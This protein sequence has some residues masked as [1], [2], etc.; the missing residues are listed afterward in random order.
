MAPKRAPVTATITMHRLYKD[1]P[2]DRNGDVPIAIRQM[3]MHCDAVMYR[4]SKTDAVPSYCLT[5]ACEWLINCEDRDIAFDDV[6]L[7]VR[8]IN[9]KDVSEIHSVTFELYSRALTA[10]ELRE[11]VR[12]LHDEY[13][14]FTSQQL[15]S[16]PCI[17]EQRDKAG[18]FRGSPFDDAENKK[19]HD[20]ANAPKH[21]AF[22]KYPFQSNKTF[23]SLC[24]PDAK[25]VCDRVR[26]FMDNKAWYDAKGIPYRL[27]ILLS[28]ESG[29]GKSSCIK[30]IA[31]MT[32]RHIVN[33]NFA[34]I[35]TSTQLRKLFQSEDLHVFEDDD[36][37]TLVK[38]NVPLNQRIYVLEEID[39]V[40]TDVINDR[41]L[42]A[43]A[44]DKIADELS[45][46][47]I[48][49]VLD[50][51]LEAP[52]RIVIV[53]SNYPERMDK[54]LVRPGRL[55]LFV[56]FGNATSETLV[57]LYEKL[58]DKSFPENYVDKLPDEELSVAEAIE[59]IF[60][61]FDASV[62]RFIIELRIYSKNKRDAEEAIL[63]EIATIA[64]VAPPETSC[65]STEVE[66]HPNTNPERTAKPAEP[67]QDAVRPRCTTPIR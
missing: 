4:A 44:P 36:K 13:V 58:N 50:G 24:G 10:N 66:W 39:A 25:Q 17:F 14:A 9:R 57:E 22:A 32:R 30:A 67:A 8:K 5:T 23:D 53:T 60:R 34:N 27:G 28:G 54:A 21:L 19:R 41:R 26:F 46:A 52:G 48:L 2:T 18:D 43:G 3:N 47:D 45:L 15:T 6:V 40:G 7:A 29:S 49:Q 42:N 59:V 56:K 38:L 55:D 64:A 63:N 61:N 65:K 12:R 20:I 11:Y 16:S 62:E 31:N 51:T 1:A 35:R 33:I 37:A